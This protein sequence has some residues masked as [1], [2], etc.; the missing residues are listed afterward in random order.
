MRITI[1]LY[2]IFS[3]IAAGQTTTIE[4]GLLPSEVSETSGLLFYN[5]VLITHNDS[6]GEPLLYEIDTLTREIIRTVQ[7]SN[8]INTDWEAISQDDDYIYIGDFG[9]NLGTRQDLA[10]HR[11]LKTDYLDSET[12]TAETIFFSYEDQSDFSDTGNSDWDA[13]AFFVLEDKL[14]ILTKQWKS[15]GCVAYEIPKIPGDYIATRKGAIENIGLVT[16]ADYNMETGALYILGYSGF[17]Q[18]FVQAH[19]ITDT[20]FSAAS[21]AI[22]LEI[23]LAQVEG[24]T[25]DG[26]AGYYISCEFFSRESPNI[27]SASRLFR[28]IQD[29]EAEPE[30]DP[31]P[32]PEPKEEE[33]LLVYREFST[34][35][36]RYQIN[37]EKL[38][39]GKRIYDVNGKT[40]WE[41]FS[42]GVSKE[43]IVSMPIPTSIY[44]FV[45]YFDNSVSSK[46]FA[47]Y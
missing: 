44:Y 34:G 7:I 26:N 45:V 43:G 21:I 22:P 6:G 30:P 38:I 20:I 8:V 4:L 23:G 5:N 15:Q 28:L 13:E 25:N 11:V 14:I 16:D 9:N 40:I 18:P 42:D 29:A 35:Q 41:Q 2:L 39:F 36:I 3:T 17:L 10:I 46:A 19:V 1:V 37:S 31:E 47:V 33:N 27:T 12:V 32:E 24:I